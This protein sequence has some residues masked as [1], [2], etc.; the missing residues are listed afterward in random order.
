[1]ACGAAACGQRA[2]SDASGAGD[3]AGA[4]VGTDEWQTQSA[5]EVRAARESAAGDIER[6]D[7]RDEY[8][9]TLAIDGLRGARYLE[10]DDRGTLYVARPGFGDIVSFRDDDGDGYFERRRT[11]VSD[12]R[13]VTGIQWKD[14]WVWFSPTDS[15]QRARDA[16]GDGRADDVEVV[17]GPD[18]LPHDGMRGHW[19]RPLLLTEDSIYTSI[20]DSGNITDETDTERQKI[21]RFDLDGSN[22][23]L[24]ASG[25][26]NTEKLRLRPGTDEIWGADHGSDNFGQRLG[27]RT[28]RVQPVT[29]FLPPDEINRYEEGGFYGHPFIV[30]DLL[31]R[32][33]YMD[34][35]NI[36]ELAS[37]TIPPK[38]G[39][40]AHS[41]SN[42]FCFVQ[43]EIVE[44]HPDALPPDH[45]GDMFVA[46][47]GSWN[48]TEKAGY[49][50][51]RIL[52]DEQTGLP[53]GQLTAVRL[54][55]GDRVLG[56]PVD[57]D[58]APDGTILF[59]EDAVGRVYGIRKRQ[60][61]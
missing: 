50:I 27:E 46:C 39:L 2:G 31:V 40:P 45:A 60:G 18:R 41:A 51:E 23:R 49:S 1:M 21:W 29:D 3:G 43:P 15:V 37:R 57:C 35:P 33:E 32:Y 4:Q 7:V 52:F 22:K 6:F 20:G 9:V 42:G 13:T 59:S 11:F 12:V 48:R 58:H 10:F 36:I 25:I 47:H 8:E 19:W 38:W 16:D 56:R 5:D 14:G 24:F 53:Y 17:I 61:D 54:L 55:E 30:G 28:G 44:A 34:R 26:R